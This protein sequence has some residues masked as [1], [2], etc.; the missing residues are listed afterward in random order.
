MPTDAELMERVRDGDMEAFGLLVARYEAK[1]LQLFHRWAGDR[2]QAE[3]CTQEVFVKLYRCRHRYS[4][5]ASFRTFLYTI[6]TNHWIDLYRQ[7]KVR[8]AECSLEAPAFSRDGRTV[9]L[10]EILSDDS[11]T[12][13]QHLQ[14]RELA[15]W[16]ERAVGRMSREH[17]D[18]WI[19]A[20][21][22]GLRYAE[23]AE[24]LRI[25][26]GTVKSRMHAATHFL[27][28]LMER[29]ANRREGKEG[30][31]GL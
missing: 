19:L 15:A 3:D 9:S 21:E 29:E 30:N 16:L 22:Q 11:P 28:R 12:P 24:I 27:R 4:P 2:S 14:A 17:R 13:A 31:E 1:L 18:V 7:R 20:Q 10:R 8:P 6:A 5:A 26:I 23:V 25:P